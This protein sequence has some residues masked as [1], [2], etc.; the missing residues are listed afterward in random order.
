R[1]CPA[2]S[3]PD[4]GTMT[5]SPSATRQNSTVPMESPSGIL[6]ARTSTTSVRPIRS[7]EKGRERMRPTRPAQC[8]GRKRTIRGAALPR[9]WPL[10]ASLLLAVVLGTSPP[11]HAQPAELRTVTLPL[12][13]DD[14][15]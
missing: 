12:A 9:A 3:V 5:F 10:V 15:Y 13:A 6:H 7:G 2:S 1:H 11:L 8:R 14:T 4:P